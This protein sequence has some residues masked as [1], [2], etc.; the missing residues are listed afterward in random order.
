MLFCSVVLRK[1]ILTIC[2]A[3][4]FTKEF[5]LVIKTSKWGLFGPSTYQMDEEAVDI[6]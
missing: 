5:I 4:P 2:S 6:A 3:L 1:K